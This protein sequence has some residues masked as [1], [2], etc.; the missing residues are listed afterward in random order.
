MYAEKR[1]EPVASLFSCERE[2]ARCCSVLTGFHV[3]Q[4]SLTLDAPSAFGTGSGGGG[5]GTGG[6]TGGGAGSAGS[7]GGGG[8]PGGGNKN[9]SNSGTKPIKSATRTKYV[10]RQ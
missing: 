8:G 9:N 10:H 6:G 7:G 1:Q 5:G 2:S 3:S 4:T